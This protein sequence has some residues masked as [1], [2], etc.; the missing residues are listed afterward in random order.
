MF[1]SGEL[2][3]TITDFEYLDSDAK[4]LLSGIL[5]IAYNSNATNFCD[6]YGVFD[7]NMFTFTDTVRD[8]FDPTRK[9][10]IQ[11]NT[12]GKSFLYEKNVSE[13]V[14]RI[15]SFKLRFDG[16]LFRVRNIGVCSKRRDK[17]CH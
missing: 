1:G 5:H 17:E 6:F 10:R 4:T 16:A 14:V 8:I 11:F 15:G 13:R 9:L 7:G 12:D 2:I 3:G